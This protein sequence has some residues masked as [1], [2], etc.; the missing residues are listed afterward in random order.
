MT[1]ARR[2]ARSPDERRTSVYRIFD[3]DG[4][5]LYV[6]VAV[7]PFTRLDTHYR[8]KPWWH[9]VHHVD[10]EWFATRQ[11]AMDEELRVIRTNIPVYNVQGC[12][13]RGQRRETPT[14]PAPVAEV[15]R[16]FWAGA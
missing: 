16:L 3:E 2:A 14:R 10:I 13:G 9:L 11:D 15:E 12:G 8:K 7:E 1:W 6:G 4:Y 5:L